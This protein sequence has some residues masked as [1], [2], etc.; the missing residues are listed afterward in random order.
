MDKPKV[1]GV[2]EAVNFPS[3]SNTDVIAKLDTGAYSGAL[4][5]A[6]LEEVKGEAGPSLKFYPL[7]SRKSVTYDEF[8]VRFVKSSNGDRQKRYF[9]ETK[10][11]IAGNT[12]PI[13]LSLTDRSDMKWQVLIG[14]KFLKQHGFIVDARKPSR[15]GKSG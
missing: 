4:H 1:V 7:S 5:C 11:K 12:Y 14:R 2:F 3:F 13:I 15:Y 8:A 10:I 6:S 9:I